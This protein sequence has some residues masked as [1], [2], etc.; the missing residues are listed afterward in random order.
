MG[1]GRDPAK[2][3]PLEEED[4]IQVNLPINMVPHGHP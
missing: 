4:L 2:G 3:L 1:A